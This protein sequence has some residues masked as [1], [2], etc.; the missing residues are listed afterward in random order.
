M[1]DLRARTYCRSQRILRFP[2]LD[3]G[4]LPLVALPRLLIGRLPVPP[5]AGQPVA[6][7]GD[8]EFRFSDAEGRVWSGKLE[9]GWPVRWAVGDPEPLVWWRRS[10]GG[11]ILSRRGGGQVRWHQEV[12]EKLPRGNGSTRPSLVPPADFKKARCDESSLP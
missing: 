2:V 1:L 10:A 12:S 9:D 11:D 6:W 5:A 8:G 3:F 7:K 4:P